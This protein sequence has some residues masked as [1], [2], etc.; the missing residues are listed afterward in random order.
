MPY[1]LVSTVAKRHK[2]DADKNGKG[3]QELLAKRIA[4]YDED[5]LCRMLLEL[6]LLESAYLRAG[7]SDDV[8]MDA[9]KRYRVDA[10]KLEKSV[11]AEFAA[12]H[13]KQPKAKAKSNSAA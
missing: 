12:K 1:D 9:A 4:A 7:T 2:V 13:S 6:T 3:P 8:L 5:L 11:A 10:E